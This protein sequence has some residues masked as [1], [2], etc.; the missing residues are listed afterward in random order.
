[1][2]AVSDSPRLSLTQ[3]ATF[4]EFGRR[5]T[6][7]EAAD[8]LGYTP[9]AI[10]QHVSALERSVNAKLV[11]KVGRQLKLTDAGNLLME[12]AALVLAAE[13]DAV[14]AVASLGN[15]VAGSLTVGTWGSTAATLMAPVVAE[16]S[17][18]YPDVVIRSREVDLDQVT[19]VVLQGAVDVAFGLNYRDAPL[20]RHRNVSLVDLL[21]EEFAIA[22][23]ADAEPRHRG[24]ID[25]KELASLRW[26]LPPATTQYGTAIRAGLRNRGVEPE[27]V[28]EVTDTAASLQLVAA[29]LGAT[30][31]TPL[32]RRLNPHVSLRSLQMTEPMSRRIVLLAL[33]DHQQRPVAAFSAVVAKVVAGFGVR[34]TG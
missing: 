19:K 8:A 33:K 17:S 32:M 29:G 6:M 4:L 5:G 14:A 30:V 23:A 9:G 31:M 34:D 11:E 16:M 1:M 22:V 7:A 20:Q 25:V 24:T 28:H 26:I 12:H 13:R 21:E 2:R 3:L 18:E 15:R 27:V 10:S